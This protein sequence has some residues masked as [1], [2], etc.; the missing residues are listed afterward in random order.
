MFIAVCIPDV[1]LNNEFVGLKADKAIELF[2][3]VSTKAGYLDIDTT[4][5]TVEIKEGTISEGDIKEYINQS[6][7]LS[8]AVKEL[9]NLNMS[10]IEEYVEELVEAGRE[11]D[12][13]ESM[14]TDFT[15]KQNVFFQAFDFNRNAMRNFLIQKPEKFFSYDF[16][17]NLFFRLVCYH[18]LV[19]E[20]RS[21]WDM[22]QNII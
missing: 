9:V 14:I 17:C 4:G 6:K 13:T 2:V 15:S 21:F 5:T 7:V 20:L 19:I 1:I 22:L 8:E 12:D 3:S 11:G 18:I 10:V 16:C